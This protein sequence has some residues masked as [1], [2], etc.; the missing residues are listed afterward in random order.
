ML[1]NFLHSDFIKVKYVHLSKVRINVGKDSCSKSK[2]VDS[3]VIQRAKLNVIQASI[4]MPF[5]SVNY[6][7][8]QSLM[9]SRVLKETRLSRN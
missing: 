2:S 8:R 7:F 4:L 9:S 3:S 6:D 1:H 5:V